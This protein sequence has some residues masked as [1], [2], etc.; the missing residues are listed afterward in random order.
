MRGQLAE[1]IGVSVFD[2]R[3]P[4]RKY[5]EV[6]SIKRPQLQEDVGTALIEEQKIIRRYA[7]RNIGQR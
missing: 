4:D 7:D 5:H 3:L 1:D 2:E 6:I